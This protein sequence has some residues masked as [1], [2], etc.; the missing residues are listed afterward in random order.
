MTTT[1]TVVGYELT[2]QLLE[3]A[4]NLKGDD[5]EVASGDCV[6]FAYDSGEP[7]CMVGHVLAALGVRLD[8]LRMKSEEAMEEWSSDEAPNEKRVGSLA[9]P[10]QFT[11]KAMTLLKTAQRRQDEGATWGS[12]LRSGVQLAESKPRYDEV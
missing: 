1:T 10:V 3:A 9:L 8:D 2:K 12:A 4:V 7:V 6:Y 5:Y 11:E